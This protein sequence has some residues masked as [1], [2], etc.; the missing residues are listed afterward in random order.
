MNSMDSATTSFCIPPVDPAKQDK[1]RRALLS[2]APAALRRFSQHRIAAVDK[3]LSRL[4]RKRLGLEQIVKYEIWSRLL[5]IIDEDAKSHLTGEEIVRLRSANLNSCPFCLSVISKIPTH[6]LPVGH[7]ID[8]DTRYPEVGPQIRQIAEKALAR[9]GEEAK[10]QF[11]LCRELRCTAMKARLRE[12]H[13]KPSVDEA[14]FIVSKTA[15]AEPGLD[16]RWLHG[17]IDRSD[18]FGEP[19]EWDEWEDLV[20]HIQNLEAEKADLQEDLVETPLGLDSQNG[21]F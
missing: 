1:A 11:L 21:L 7:F 18:A 10:S 5:K 16:V 12:Q 9:A 6:P 2:S 20:L 19:E 15:V 14:K 13:L 8:L 4:H 3:E 17:L